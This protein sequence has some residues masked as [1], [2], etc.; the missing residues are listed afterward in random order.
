M[1]NKEA[2]LGMQA[3]VSGSNGDGDNP[4]NEEEPAN[5]SQINTGDDA[6][7]KVSQATQVISLLENL[8][9]EFFQSDN[10]VFAT[11]PTHDHHET[12]PVRR[13]G[14]KQWAA[15]QFYLCH[16]KTPGSQALQDALTTIEGKAIHESRHQDVHLRIGGSEE[17]IY[18]DLGGDDWKMIH[19][20]GRG[21]NI[22]PHGTIKFTRGVG[23]LPLPVPQRGGSLEMLRPFINVSSED[24]WRLF[25]GWLVN[26]L[27][28]T[29]PQLGIQFDGEQGT[30]K[31]TVSEI[32]KTIIDPNMAGKRSEPREIRDLMI[33]ARSNWLLAFDNL[34]ALPMWLSDGLCRLSTGGSFGTR[35]LYS[36]EDETLFE[37]KRPVI[38]NGIGS[39]VTRPDLLDRYVV[40]SLE[41]IPENKRRSEKEFWTEFRSVSGLILG[42]LCDVLSSVIAQR[43]SVK[44]SGLPRMA[45]AVLWATSAESSLGWEAGAFQESYSVNREGANSTALESSLLYEP[46][47]ELLGEVAQWQGTA[48]ELLSA[49]STIIGE[50]KTKQRAWPNSPRAL[51][52]D[53]QR[54]VPNLRSIG[55][56]VIFSAKRQARSR[57]LELERT[58]IPPSTSSQPTPD[59][60][61]HDD[62]DDLFG[63]NQG[64][65]KSCSEQGVLDL[66]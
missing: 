14:F 54:I 15:Y 4:Q 62:N 25:V 47:C 63:Q 38:I 30:G 23:M 51:R 33:A 26:T 3:A 48:G 12:W 2:L 10:R 8:K 11:F 45:D 44:V 19:I 55:I 6:T 43:P 65:S 34:S 66:C 35:Q 40:L 20:T 53:L 49:L 42:G 57:I 18:V 17:E 1:R 9:C 58:G 50:A 24:D 27:R 36:D 32:L 60:D 28:P 22:V 41:Q 5:C 31:T 37:A 59:R 13:K 56:K 7:K 39:V 46:L 21:W 52:S 16:K 64:Q 61:G 29:G